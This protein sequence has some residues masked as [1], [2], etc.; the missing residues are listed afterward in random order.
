MNAG[1][2]EIAARRDWLD[3]SLTLDLRDQHGAKARQSQ[4]EKQVNEAKFGEGQRHGA[5]LAALLW[6]TKRDL[7]RRGS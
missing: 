1:D 2:L 4:R 7:V 6:K 5:L 3:A